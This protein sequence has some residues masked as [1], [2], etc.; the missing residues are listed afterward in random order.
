MPGTELAMA[1]SLVSVGGP[2]LRHSLGLAG[3]AHPARCDQVIGY[4]CHRLRR[5]H[6]GAQ[7]RVGVAPGGGPVRLASAARQC[8]HL[9]R[10]DRRGKDHPHATRVLA[11]AWLYIIWLG[12]PPRA[13]AGR[14]SLPRYQKKPKLIYV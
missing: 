11:H 9:G 3:A 6:D 1:S 10:R 8:P 14:W 12:V 13:R 5:A 7:R 2:D 4:S